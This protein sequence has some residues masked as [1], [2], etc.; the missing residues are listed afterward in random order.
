MVEILAII[1]ARG[2]SKGLPRKNIKSLGRHPLIAYSIAA[3]LSA[4][5]VNRVIVSTDDQ[6]IADRA[7]DYGAEVPFIRPSEHAR[8]ETRD[9]PVFLHAL[10]WFSENEGYQPD[11]VIQLRPTSP[12][13]PEFLV[14]EAIKVI[15]EN[16]KG[17]ET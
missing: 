2:G 6:E 11:L 15:Q 14:D 16:P 12:F 1:P 8:D 13:R 5:Q 7:R 3:G 9:L 10:D 17:F 4:E